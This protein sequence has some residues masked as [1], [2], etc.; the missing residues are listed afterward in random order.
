M[1]TKAILTIVDVSKSERYKE[2][3]NKMDVMHGIISRSF[4]S[5][6]IKKLF[7]CDNDQ[8]EIR[9]LSEELPNKEH[10]V[11][12]LN[13]TLN[14]IH[15]YDYTSRLTKLNK[16]ST[17]SFMFIGNPVC[18]KKGKRMPIK[19]R[20]GCKEWFISRSDKHGFIVKDLELFTLYP[21]LGKESTYLNTVQYTGVL[22]IRDEYL[23]KKTIMQGIGY[24]KCF[25]FGLLYVI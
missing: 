11:E 16:G 7:Q 18:K 1:S 19:E 8:K 13:I 22:E 3:R 5:K 9:I 20:E 10:I 24:E 23:F 25:G 2:I 6:E 14:D 4:S 15:S 12:E 17:H 21:Y